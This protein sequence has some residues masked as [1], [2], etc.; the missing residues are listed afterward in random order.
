[1]ITDQVKVPTSFH[2]SSTPVADVGC[3]ST[4][5]PL[6]AYKSQLINGMA[7][8]L[9]SPFSLHHLSAFR[10]DSTDGDQRR[11]HSMPETAPCS[12]LDLSQHFGETIPPT[13]YESGLARRF[14]TFLLAETGM[15]K[16]MIRR[17]WNVQDL[18]V[19]YSLPASRFSRVHP[20]DR[21]CSP[22]VA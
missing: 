15:F 5:C 4:T 6:S 2:L 3:I 10:V 19:D 18:A 9:N 17:F 1:M 22:W 16:T 20:V 21:R 11:Q 12:A 13:W 14:K 7:M 8:L